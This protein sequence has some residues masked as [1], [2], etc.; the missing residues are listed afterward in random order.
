MAKIFDQIRIKKP[1]Y[2][3]FDLSHENKLSMNMADLVPCL[4]QE[5]VPGDKI[6]LQAELMARV[7]PMLAPVMHRVDIYTHFFFVPNR[8]IW[9]D[10]ENFI[11]GNPLPN[12][13]LAVLPTEISQNFSSSKLSDYLGLPSQAVSNQNGVRFSLLPFGAYQLI[14][15]EY[16]RDQNLHEIDGL[17][18]QYLDNLASENFYTLL[19]LRKRCWQKDYFTS[20]LP[21]AQ[22]GGDIHLPIG[23]E[24][25]YHYSPTKSQYIRNRSGII[26]SNAEVGTDNNGFLYDTNSGEEV[27]LDPNGTY[28]LDNST[29][30]TINELR[31][32]I[33]L[34][35]WL[36]KN[37]RAGSRYVE[38]IFSHFGVKSPDARLQRPEYL[39]GGKSPLVISEV[40]QTSST[41][42]TS[43]QGTMSGHGLSVG[44]SHSFQ[45]NVQEHGY[46]MGIV[47]IL[48]KTSYFQGIP[49]HFIKYDRFDYF[50]PE[51]AHLGEQEVKNCELFYGDDNQNN[52]V[53][54][55]QSRYAEYKFA[56]D[57]VHGNFRNNLSYWHLARQFGNRPNLNGEFVKAQSIDRIFPVQDN[58]DKFLLQLYF[59]QNMLRP[60]PVFGTPTF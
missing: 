55:Y 50:W 59:K 11:T 5:V 15:N 28:K 38:Q 4:V 56:P 51:F 24:V 48:P 25:E 12:G 20:A 41:D 31:R 45:Y 32:S 33:K 6:R 23:S 17:L 43:P 8:I 7:M 27:Y 29:N 34:Q 18:Q 14:Y 2:N 3:S 54:G 39:G 52:E 30:P 47:S 60:M 37:A 49:K 26:V 1:R 46:I 19:S 16:Y 58:T 40:L 21:W 36:E 44:E 57:E 53:F 9:K 10:W 13:T 42:S 35:E 22:K